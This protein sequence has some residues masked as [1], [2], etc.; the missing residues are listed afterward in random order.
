M[1]TKIQCPHCSQHY[2]VSSEDFGATVACQAC[3]KDFVI[4]Q[5]NMDT[6]DLPKSGQVNRVTNVWD[7]ILSFWKNYA[8]FRGRA[9]RMEFVGSKLFLGI[10]MILL[11]ASGSNVLLKGGG[12][13][14][15]I[16][17]LAIGWRRLHDVGKSGWIYLVWFIPGIGILLDFILCCKDSQPRDNQYGS[18]PKATSVFIAGSII[19]AF[20]GIPGSYFFQNET[21]RKS[22]D[23][24]GGY[25]LNLSKCSDTE[26]GNVFLGVV[27]FF[28]AGVV[29]D[30]IIAK[31]TA[32]S[33]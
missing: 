30:F 16:P 31:V 7:A 33:A 25:L 27:V 4:A 32:K 9:S 22:F 21:V 8:K 19:G 24:V 23:G 3:G 15:L 12:L 13:A 20:V 18:N 14:M 17:C 29:V 28:A 10:I 5:P 26:I 2:E 1:M 11:A 6:Q